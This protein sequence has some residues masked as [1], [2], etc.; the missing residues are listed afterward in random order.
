MS[1]TEDTG[2]ERVTKILRTA[3][4]DNASDV[5]IEVF[6]NKAQVRVRIDGA[7]HV[8]EE[9]TT[10]DQQELVAAVKSFAGMDVNEQRPQDG[11]INVQLNDDEVGVRVSTAPTLCGESVVL[12][13]L[14]NDSLSVSLDRLGLWSEHRKLLDSWIERPCGLIIV[15]GPAGSGKSTMLY[16]I[17]DVLNTVQRKT[18]SIEDPVVYAISGINQIPVNPRKGLTFA[19]AM[20]TAMRQDPDILVI[21]E[22]REQVTAGMLVSAAVT[23]HLVLT[24]MHTSDAVQSC[25]RMLDLGVQPYILGDALIGSLSMRLVRRLCPDCRKAHSP[26]KATRQSLQLP[27]G[28]Y[29][30]PV[31]CA[32]CHDSGY[33]LRAGIY[34]LYAPTA[35]TKALMLES[36]GH[37]AIREQAK[38]DGL[39]TLWDDAIAKAA[40]GITSI[41][42]AVRVTGGP[43]AG[44][45]V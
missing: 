24:T 20:R 1:K 45:P 44:F 12:R 9:M 30:K 10:D 19:S 39:L 28:T 33:R 22:V 32:N 35:A 4:Q 42:E 31:G 3:I 16:S 7:L 23:G 8:A 6:D 41:S 38:A 36:A 34:E 25:T 26:D 37:N 43:Q 40:Q 13:I 17:V 11:R 2:K 29:F 18:V 5:H 27:E 15:G 14:K 21:D